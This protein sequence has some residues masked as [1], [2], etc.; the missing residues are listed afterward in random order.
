MRSIVPRSMKIVA[1]S[2]VK[3]DARA[4]REDREVLV[5]VRAVELEGIGAGLP[6]DDVAVVA[7]R[8]GHAI[9]AAPAG[10]RVVA[11]AAGQDVVAGT[12]RERVHADAAE[13]RVVAVPAAQRVVAAAAVDLIVAAAALQV[14][15]EEIRGGAADDAIVAGAAYDAVGPVAGVDVE[16]GERGQARAGMKLSLP[17]SIVS[18][19]ISVPAT[20]ITIDATSRDNNARVPFGDSA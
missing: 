1:T 3:R 5:R 13:N 11:L 9:V 14:V 6:V 16:R 7:R 17:P 19:R 2:R 20:S 12:A 18:S 15:R 4:V 8:P 10:D